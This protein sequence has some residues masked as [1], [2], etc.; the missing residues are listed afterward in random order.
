MWWEFLKVE[1]RLFGNCLRG[2]ILCG[3]GQNC[4]PHRKSGCA[5]G[6]G[7]RKGLCSLD[8]F[9]VNF[10]GGTR[11]ERDDVLWLC[12]RSMLRRPERVESGTKVCQVVVVCE[13]GK[14]I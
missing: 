14:Y 1:A 13:Y 11:V 6:S 5:Y 9:D 2:N 8:H 10:G 7:V 12:S 4:G 3:L